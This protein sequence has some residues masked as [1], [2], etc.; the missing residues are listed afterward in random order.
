MHLFSKVNRTQV[1]PQRKCHISCVGGMLDRRRVHM[2]C[3]GWRCDHEELHRRPENYINQEIFRSMQNEAER[4]RGFTEKTA[5][6]PLCVCMHLSHLRLSLT[7]PIRTF[8]LIKE[9]EIMLI[10]FLYISAAVN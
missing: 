7:L 10:S 5:P 3:V 9:K 1:E 2:Q 6:L 8:R 4:Q